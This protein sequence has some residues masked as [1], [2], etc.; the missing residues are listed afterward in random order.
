MQVP[1]GASFTF[2]SSNGNLTAKVVGLTVETPTA[3]LV[4]MSGILD[5]AS[6]N[7]LVPTKQWRGGSISVEYIDA[8]VDPQS[9]VTSVGVVTFSAPNVTVSKRAILESA[10]RDIRVGEVI[11]GTLKFVLTDYTG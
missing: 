9:F 4:D 10:S 1:T 2:G 11:R 6:Y 8:T 5:G 3:E 7:I